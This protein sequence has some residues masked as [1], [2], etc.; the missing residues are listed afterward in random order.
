MLSACVVWNKEVKEREVIYLSKPIDLTGQRFG[1]LTVVEMADTHITPKGRNVYMWK[2]ICDC[3][4]QAIVATS[5]L[6][7]GQSKSCGCYQR[8]KAHQANFDDLTGKRFGRLV[9]VEGIKKDNGFYW[10]CKCD[11]G[12]YTE[13]LPQHLKRNLIRSCGC[14][15]V[16]VS[17]QTNK[18]HGMKETRLYKVWLDM[19]ARCCN[20][21][22][23]HY[24]DYGGR[25]ITVCDE[26]KDDFMSFYEWAI[27][28]GYRDNLTIDRKDVN[29][30]YEPSNCRWATYKEQAN[31]KRANIILEYKGRKQTMAEWA[32]EIGMNYVTFQRR[33]KNYKWSIEKAIE[34][35]VKKK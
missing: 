6:R 2:C 30:N 9:A 35:P 22:D 14:L 34:T 20:S 24:K 8:E 5:S 1:R 12:N 13:V 16:E 27:A 25:G 29:G 23:S 28:N 18:R 32:E 31:N 3:G 26:W 19:K 15:R 7:S 33:I 10:K 21:S 4:N 17:S 11:C